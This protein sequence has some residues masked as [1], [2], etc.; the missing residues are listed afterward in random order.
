MTQSLTNI[1]LPI[2]KDNTS[3]KPFLDISVTH[4]PKDLSD[5]DICYDYI[6]SDC[7]LIKD[8]NFVIGS[9]YT[10]GHLI[11]NCSSYVESFDIPILYFDYYFDSD[12]NR[13]KAI[14]TAY[15]MDKEAHRIPID[16][17]TVLSVYGKQK[18]VVNGSYYD[19]VVHGFSQ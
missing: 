7:Y 1:I 11:Y 18:L 9:K 10:N 17:N 5:E 4:I 2:L 19:L 15:T 14:I 12:N 13:V 3:K 16:K 6:K 8:P